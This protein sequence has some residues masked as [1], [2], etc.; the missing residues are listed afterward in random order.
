MFKN[1]I[2]LL[3]C[4]SF[5]SFYSQV[6]PDNIEIV[7]GQYGTPHIFSKTD[8]EATYGLAW[9]HAEDDFKTIQETFLPVK[10]FMGKYK[11]AE[12][13][14]LDYVIQLLKCKETVEKQFGNL[15]KEVV[16][17][18]EGYVEGL[19][20][21][22]A[23][24]P[25]EVLIKKTFPITVKEYLTGYN[26]V[27]HF[28]SDTGD[29][30]KNLFGN[31]ITPLKDVSLNT[32]G[33]NGFAFRKQKTIENKTYL[34]VN[35]H[36]PLEGPF[37]WYE[38]H[39]ITDQG[40]NMLGGLFPGSPFPFI[41]TNENLGWTHTYNYPDLIDLYQLEMHPKRKYKYK[42]DGQWIKLE[43]SKAKLK[44]KLKSG[45]VI[46]VRRKVL[47]CKYGPVIKNES[48]AFSFHSNALENIS[49][50]D[51]WYQMNKAA[52]FTEFKT[53]LEIIG[54]PRF[55]LIY[56]D[57][58]DNIFYLS[59]AKIPVR[60][61][62]F[63]WD[64][65][66]PGNTSKTLTTAYHK[67]EDLP[68]LLN[69]SKG[70]LFNT[71][72][73]PFNCAHPEDN[74]LEEDYSATFSFR[75]NLNNRSLRF[76]ELIKQY[77]KISYNDFVRI[78]YDQQYPTPIFCPF[79][80]NDV[81]KIDPAVSPGLK[82][83]ITIIQQWDKKATVD[84]LGAAQWSVYYKHL[85]KS[86]KKFNLNKD[87]PIA[88][89]VIVNSLVY[90]R[91]YFIKHFNRIDVLHGEFQKHI[92]AGVELPVSGLV[93]M[94]A[95]TSTN[96]FIN[97]KVKA[98]SGDSYIMLVRYGDEKVEIETVLPYGVSTHSDSPHYTDQM[99]LYVNHQRKRMSLDKDEIYKT[100]KKI[101]HPK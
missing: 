2:S 15:S 80:V 13:A 43:K 82:E 69:P 89:S 60:D 7:R 28:F 76:E 71:N 84:N 33:S 63:K 41:G 54:V 86:V 48:G 101:Y 17:V 30:L 14:Q 61:T 10:G 39:M 11:G 5:I 45:I 92:R 50:I 93:D 19:N 51:Q 96:K 65:L 90:T 42:F 6:N 53:A 75:E 59:N 52:D 88:D 31:K 87:L 12:G 18:I 21:Y 91:E 24:H 16:E 55:N 67:L 68:Q 9:A 81:F 32:I 85:K 36:Q 26:L 40:W 4:C 46:P 27:I 94:I 29:V 23:A 56:A 72:N 78:K 73:S 58:M 38:A 66:L 25:N 44:V 97:G 3:I 22:A 47:W 35:T 70:Y 37:A 79:Q 95:A 1:F 8:K 62:L 77:D 49:S 74:P 99:S 57:K 98:V 100:A 83:L 34:N 20:A 64:E